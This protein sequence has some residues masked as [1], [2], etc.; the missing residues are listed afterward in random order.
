MH[1]H[2]IFALGEDIFLLLEA[3]V[4]SFS[5]EIQLFLKASL[6]SEASFMSEKSFL[7]KH[8]S[9]LSLSKI[10]FVTKS[11][12]PHANQSFDATANRGNKSL[13]KQRCVEVINNANWLERLADY[14][15]V[16]HSSSICCC[17]YLFVLFFSPFSLICRFNKHIK[18]VVHWTKFRNPCCCC[19]GRRYPVVQRPMMVQRPQRPSMVQCCVASFYS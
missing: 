4:L 9:S 12:F 19:R 15:S 18:W 13:A 11:S 5:L 7:Q 10:N 1:L 3:F 17:Y 2:G 6:K 14:S 8:E 16:C